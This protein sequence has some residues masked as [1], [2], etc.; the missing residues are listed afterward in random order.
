MVICIKFTCD[1]HV[2]LLMSK[3][4][5]ISCP[6][7][8]SLFFPLFLSNLQATPYLSPLPTAFSLPH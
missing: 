7:F 2:V 1:L 3:G 6:C 5:E 4:T 8:F